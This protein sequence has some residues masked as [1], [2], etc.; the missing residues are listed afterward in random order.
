MLEFATE[1]FKTRPAEKMKRPTL[2]LGFAGILIPISLYLL[3]P[4]C[5]MRDS[6]WALTQ[7]LSKRTKE[8]SDKRRS[9][10]HFPVARTKQRKNYASTNLFL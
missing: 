8:Q 4:I 2:S 10:K 7:V 1:K 6:V 3:A 5:I 9:I